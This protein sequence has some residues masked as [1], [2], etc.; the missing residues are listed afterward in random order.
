[1]PDRM[2]IIDSQL[3]TSSMQD[4]EL[5][6]KDQYRVWH[7]M[8]RKLAGE[9]SGKELQELQELLQDHP[10]IQYSMQ[11]LSDLAMSGKAQ[12]GGPKNR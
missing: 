6:K 5:Q 11:V 2:Q 8:A 7:L 12:D 9:A 1:M 10:H 4:N 3:I